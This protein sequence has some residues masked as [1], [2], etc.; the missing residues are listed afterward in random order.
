MGGTASTDFR[1]DDGPAIPIPVASDANVIVGES[2]V[3]TFKLGL[4]CC[5]SGLMECDGVGRCVIVRMRA[6]RAAS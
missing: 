3:S 2:A 5:G 1:G 4:G 6:F